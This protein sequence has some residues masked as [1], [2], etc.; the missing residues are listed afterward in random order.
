M[1][2]A[3]PERPTPEQVLA[4]VQAESIQADI[5]K[6]AAASVTQAAVPAAKGDA[7]SAKTHAMEETEAD[8]SAEVVAEDVE[9]ISEEDLAEAKK[10]MKMDM[11]AKHKG[12]MGAI[13]DFFFPQI[14]AQT[15]QKVSDVTA[16]LTVPGSQAPIETLCPVFTESPDSLG[17]VGA[18]KSG[19][20][21][22]PLHNYLVVRSN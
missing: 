18:G 15:P 6:K 21:C 14:T 2:P 10:K 11:V 1:P 19:D 7:K 20:S 12:S 3:K 17:S 22:P 16:A 13:R 4:Q 5:Q 8:E 9:E